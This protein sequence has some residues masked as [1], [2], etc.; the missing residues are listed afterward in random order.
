MEHPHLSV[1][2][3]VRDGERHLA[4]AV[5]SILG[6]DYGDF[7]F[8][9]VN[10]G[11]IDRTGEILASYEARDKRIQLFTNPPGLTYVEGRMTAIQ[12]VNT[13]WVAIMDSDDIAE[14]HR[15]TQQMKLIAAHGDTIGALGSWAKYID[16]NGAILGNMSMEPTSFARFDQM[17]RNGDPIVLVDPSAIIHRPT[18][19]RAGGYRS[20][21]TPAADLDLWYRI[22]E[23]DRKL[24]ITPEY[25]MRYRV[26]SGSDSVRKTLFQRKKTHFINYN[27]RLRR[28]GER[29]ISWAD[30]E[31][32][33]WS[34]TSYR[35]PRLHNDL[36]M[37][38][39]KRAGLS[40]GEKKYLSLAANLFVA[41][42]LKPPLVV[43]RL[44]H[45]KLRPTRPSGPA[46]TRQ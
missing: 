19:L 30:Y 16:A 36:A 18:F 28:S 38:F 11:S 23:L 17:Y 14:P 31:A 43:E 12:Q 37:M 5:E 9:I 20:E 4:V 45:Q 13:E 34:K 35:I 6:Q 26:H 29:E 44:F 7:R 24:L 1:V 15:F 39:Y 25:L 41:T 8:Y 2:M 46:L 3:S 10:N 33:I 27:M 32:Y 40:Y 22:A 21:C 42:L